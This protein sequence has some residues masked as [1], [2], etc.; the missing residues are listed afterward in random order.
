MLES[1][2]FLIIFVIMVFTYV[3][4]LCLV[5]L[6]FIAYLKRKFLNND[7]KHLL[8]NTMNSYIRKT[9]AYKGVD[10]KAEKAQL[11]QIQTTNASG[12]DSI[13]GSE[14]AGLINLIPGKAKDKIIKGIMENPAAAMDVIRGF[15][16]A[17]AGAGPAAAQQGIEFVD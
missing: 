1:G 4:S 8:T 16:E 11:Q 7:L 12:L 6:I 13:V 14:I 3:I 15:Q 2:D 17:Q 9:R 10:A 5:I